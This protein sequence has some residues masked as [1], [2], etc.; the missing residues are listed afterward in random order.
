MIRKSPIV[1][2]IPSTTGYTYRF[3][4]NSVPITKEFVEIKELPVLAKKPRSLVGTRFE[5][6]RKFNPFIVVKSPTVVAVYLVCRLKPVFTRM[7]LSPF[8]TQLPEEA[9]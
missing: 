5:L 3:T 7:R 8:R 9:E 6:S 4:E 1:I 2:I